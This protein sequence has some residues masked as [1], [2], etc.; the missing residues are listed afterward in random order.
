MLK[1]PSICDHSAVPI[2]P[3]TTMFPDTG[4]DRRSQ[5]AKAL[6]EQAYTRQ[7]RGEFQEAV[8]LY[9]QSIETLPTA[10]AYTFLGWTYRFMGDLDAAIEECK[11]AIL[12]DPTLGNPYNDIGAYLLDLERFDEAIEWLRKATM[13]RRYA[14]YHYP[15]FNLGRAHAALEQWPESLR[16][17]EKAAELAPDYLAAREAASKI[18][19]MMQ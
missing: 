4:Q 3:S 8:L 15:W 9:K 11:N 17:F 2:I 1:A 12:I 10:E 14:S 5:A 7:M 18:R 19:R 16:C 13:S 6:F